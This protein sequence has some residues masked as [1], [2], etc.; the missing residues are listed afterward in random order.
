MTFM[1]AVALLREA[2]NELSV[3]ASYVD[4]P[5]TVWPNVGLKVTAKA[6]KQL[7]DLIDAALATVPPFE[8]T[9]FWPPMHSA[10]LREVARRNGA[11]PGSDLIDFVERMEQERDAALAAAGAAKV[12]EPNPNTE[13][14]LAAPP[15]DAVPWTSNGGWK[16]VF[17][18]GL[19]HRNL[20]V[21][22]AREGWSWKVTHHGTA[23]TPE[24]ARAA[25]ERAARGLR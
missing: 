7:R 21:R 4:H 16:E 13:A 22:K 14:A 2:R 5:D 15:A 19:P 23:D 20:E 18:A 3:L 11:E 24:N 6:Q 17:R 8:R 1:E 9:N 12:R 10:R 25:A